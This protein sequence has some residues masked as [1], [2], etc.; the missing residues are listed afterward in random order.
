M[1]N[2]LSKIKELVIPFKL[3]KENVPFGFVVLTDYRDE[4]Y[5]YCIKQNIYCNIHWKDTRNNL[6]N[7]ILTFPCDQRYQEDEMRYIIEKVTEF[8]RR[9]I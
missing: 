2:E 8:F 4:L 9:K 3:K 6:S 7:K 5:N 1:Y